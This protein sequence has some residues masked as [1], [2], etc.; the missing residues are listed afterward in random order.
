[1]GNFPE[2]VAAIKRRAR[3]LMLG[4]ELTEFP[5][6]EEFVLQCNIHVERYYKYK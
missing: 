1:M 6:V 2:A 5:R 3:I 4:L